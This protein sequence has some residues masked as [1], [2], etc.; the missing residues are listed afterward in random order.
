M[1]DTDDPM[2]RTPLSSSTA[3]PSGTQA[4]GVTVESGQENTMPPQV[5]QATG[6]RS[7]TAANE[8]VP[9]DGETVSVGTAEAGGEPAPAEEAAAASSAPEP[10]VAIEPT[11][12]AGN[13]TEKLRAAV[14]GSIAQHEA[15]QKQAMAILERAASVSFRGA[16]DDARSD[17]ARITFKLM[18]FAQANIRSNFELARDYAGARSIPEIVGVQSAYFKRQ[19]ELMNRQADELRKLTA[20][21]ATKRAA[22]F[23]VTVTHR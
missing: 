15:E 3:T 5:D 2:H 8:N 6:L 10:I 12:G 22:Q 13:A 23:Q 17:A 20:E 9:V 16:L 21:I 19:M 18:E 14:Q 4:L 11:S 1:S 7:D